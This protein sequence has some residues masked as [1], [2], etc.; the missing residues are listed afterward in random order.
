MRTLDEILI[1]SAKR[2]KH[3]CPRQ[4]LGARMGLF[5]AELLGLELPRRDKRLLVISETDGCAV[6]GLIAATGCRVGS[7]TLR[8]LDFGKVAATFADIYTEETVRI[9]PRREARR[10]AEGHMPDARNNWEAMLLGYQVLPASDLFSVQ[11][12]ELDKPL[13]Q[14]VSRPG[15]KAICE[16][17]GEEIINGREI[18]KNDTVLCRA[19][20]GESYYHYAS[21][22][23]L[24]VA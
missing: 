6:D 15:A 24:A 4:V 20:A 11:P 16:A 14:I 9:V 13:A 5:A 3:L 21:A 19:C 2:H 23:S 8:I 10:L 12:V 18:L 1:D 7:R 17:C 22:G